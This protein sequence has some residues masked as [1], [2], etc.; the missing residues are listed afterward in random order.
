MEENETIDDYEFAGV[1][2]DMIVLDGLKKGRI[3]ENFSPAIDDKKII[4]Y[5]IYGLRK[6]LK[7]INELYA[8]GSSVKKEDFIKVLNKNRKER[9]DIVHDF[10]GKIE[11]YPDKDMLQIVDRKEKNGEITIRL[12]RIPQEQKKKYIKSIVAQL[13]EKMTK[14]QIAAMME[15]AI[16]KLNDIDTIK[17]VNK[18]LKTEKPK[19]EGK[20][21]CYRLTVDNIDIWTI[22]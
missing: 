8:K 6:C 18:K 10:L 14:E 20:R 9:D 21:G 17:K 7:E 1:G 12:K 11:N 4:H 16:A 2:L 13:M 5:D 22:A 15:Q 19:I 3:L